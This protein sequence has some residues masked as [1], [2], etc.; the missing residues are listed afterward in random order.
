MIVSFDTNRSFDFLVGLPNSYTN[1][2]LLPV[3]SAAGSSYRPVRDVIGRGGYGHEAKK[4]ARK[5]GVGLKAPKLGSH[6]GRKLGGI[7]GGYVGLGDLG[8][9]VGAV[10]G[11]FAGKIARTHIGGSGAYVGANRG[12]GGRGAYALAH[13]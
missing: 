12:L 9:R 6:F 3:V 4:M 11:R 8:G 2:I 1:P 7:A 10:A 5:S 13:R